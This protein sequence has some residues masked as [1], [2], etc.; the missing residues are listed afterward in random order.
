LPSAGLHGS[1]S[2][3]D[4]GCA[5]FT[6]HVNL[7]HDCLLFLFPMHIMHSNLK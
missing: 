5:C 2:L 4:N 6:S 7:F 3:R 1:R